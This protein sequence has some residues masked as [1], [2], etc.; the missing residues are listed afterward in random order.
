MHEIHE[1][2]AAK[3]QVLKDLNEH[4]S[5]Y[6]DRLNSIDPRLMLYIEDAISNNGSHANLMELL[7]IRKE[8]RLCDSYELN[9]E[10]VKLWLRAIEGIWDNGQH[11][12]GGLKFDTPR[13]NDHVMLMPY[14]MWCLFGKLRRLVSML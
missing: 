8:L 9:P 4:L 14:Q 3:V 13:G 12:K 11:V 1:Y 2:K 6:A 7:G 5:D 10:R